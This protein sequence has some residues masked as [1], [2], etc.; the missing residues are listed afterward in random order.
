MNAAAAEKVP[1]RAKIAVMG[2]LLGAFMAVLNIQV[3]NTSL[4]D[5]QGGIG[6]GLD[7][8]GWIS[9]AYLLSLIHI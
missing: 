8:G 5:I 2:A 4:P 6:T 7:N 3:T 9:T 1:L